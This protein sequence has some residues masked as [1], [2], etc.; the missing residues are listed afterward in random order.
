M[1][2]GE[3]EQSVA[4]ELRFRGLPFCRAQLSAYIASAWPI[5]VDDP[6][7]SRWAADFAGSMAWE[8]PTALQAGPQASAAAVR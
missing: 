4:D 8:R 6:C 2:P 5:I 7:V 1:E 3:F